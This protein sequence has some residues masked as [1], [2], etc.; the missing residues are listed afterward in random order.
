MLTDDLDDLSN[1]LLRSSAHAV[2]VS[3]RAAAQEKTDLRF[4]SNA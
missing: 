4:I 2:P 1:R 3:R